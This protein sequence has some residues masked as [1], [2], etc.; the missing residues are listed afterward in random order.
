MGAQAEEEE[1][2]FEVVTLTLSL[3]QSLR[4]FVSLFH[5]THFLCLA[6]DFFAFP[7]SRHVVE[8]VCAQG[9]ALPA[10]GRGS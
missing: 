7:L 1:E 10:C 2:A 6:T 5:H 3:A 9:P 4:L 8:S